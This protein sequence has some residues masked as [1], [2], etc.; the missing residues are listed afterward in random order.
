[1]EGFNKPSPLKMEGNVCENFKI[2]KQEVEI[3]FSATETDLKQN[4]VQIARLLNLMGNEALKVYNVL[5]V[6]KNKDATVTEILTAF[7]V[8]CNPKKN[9]AMEHYKFF[10]YHQQDGEPFMQFYTKLRQLIM[11]CEFGVVEK[12]ILRSQVILGLYNKDVQEKLLRDDPTLEKAVEC[13]ISAEIAEGARKQLETTEINEKPLNVMELRKKKFEWNGKNKNCLND[14]KSTHTATQNL[15]GNPKFKNP[16]YKCNKHHGWGNCPAF[17]KKCE[18]C[19]Q[20]NHFAV[21]CRSKS[22]YNDGN[23][24]VG[25]DSR[26]VHAVYEEETNERQHYDKFEVRPLFSTNII[27]PGYVTKEWVK[28][29]KIQN[30]NI[31]FKLDTGAHTNVIN[32]IVYDSLFPKPKLEQTNIRLEAYGG[33]QIKPVGTC[34]AQCESNSQA[35]WV[36]FIIVQEEQC[37]PILG[38]KACM[39]LG[40]IKR[41]D[42]IDPFYRNRNTFIRAYTDQFSG[43]GCFP[44]KYKILLKPDACPKANPARRVPIILIDRLKNS[45]NQMVSEGIISPVAD[46]EAHEWVSNLVIVEKPD[47]SLRLCLD[48]QHLNKYIIRDHYH[49]PTLEEIKSKLSHKNFYT[50]LDLKNGF[51]HVELDKDSS[52]LC[53]FSS[54]F[55]LY[56][57]KRMP[58]GISS[59]PEVFQKLN[60]KYFGDIEGLIIYFDDFFIFHETREGHDK[61]VA[62][63]MKRAKLYNVKFNHRKVQYCQDEV[64]FLGLIFNK[65]GVS[66]DQTR[67]DSIANLKN[68]NNKKELMQLMGMINYLRDFIPN[69]SELTSPLRGLLKKD[70]EWA[71]YDCHTGALEKIKKLICEAPILANFDPNKET[72]LQCDSSKD[73]L[74]FCLMQEK[75]P[76]SFG[77]RSLTESEQNYAQI[78]KEL[79]AVSYACEKSHLYIYGRNV[80]IYTDHQPLVS[81]MR[82]NF[83]DIKNNRLK[84]IKLKLLTYDLDVQYLPGKYMYI[85]DLLSR[86]FIRKRESDD[87]AMKDVIHSLDS[88]VTFTG[89]NLAECQRETLN[90]NDLK[91]VLKWCKIGW[92]NKLKNGS[93]VSHYFRNRNEIISEEGLLYLNGKL[94]VPKV[95]RK[96]YL[97]IL[98]E[99]HLG[100]VKTKLKARNFIYWPGLTSDIT[101]MISTCEVCLRFSNFNAKNTLIQ[102][103]FPK[104]PFQKIGI[105]IATFANCSYLVIEDYY[106]KWLEVEKLFDKT[107]KSVIDSLMVLFSRFG[108]PES[109][110]SDN[111]PFDSYEYKRF[112]RDWNFKIITS[113]PHFPQSNGMAEKGVGIAKD[114]LRKCL[115]TSSDYQLFLLNYRSSPIA[116][117][118]VSPAQLMFNREIRTK[119]PATLAS[120]QPQ[121]PDISRQLERN[122]INQARY[123][124]RTAKVN[125]ISHEPGEVVM[126]YNVRR[127]IWEKAII[128]QKLEN[129]RS[130]FVKCGSGRIVRRNIRF[131]KKINFKTKFNATS[132]RY[133]DIIINGPENNS[134]PVVIENSQRLITDEVPVPKEMPSD[135]QR[136]HAAPVTSETPVISEKSVLSE[137]ERMS[138]K[139]R[140]IRQPKILD[141]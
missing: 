112:S 96:K 58:F 121:I 141:L 30:N 133:D 80:K 98:H 60:T 105:D 135:V 59:A 36:K 74:G 138:S 100:I 107:S 10:K 63:V 102:R 37:Q 9:L 77:S 126:M 26:Q 43:V 61:I 40:L 116:N 18:A 104:Y 34:R 44:E 15:H 93:E 31:E 82:K 134:I 67:I 140:V 128:I 125:E 78:E 132:H 53:I 14:G 39:D 2:F 89:T 95:L 84:R 50:V 91:Q 86:N 131:L 85:A 35:L 47:S 24:N 87:V 70:N 23:R 73:A 83:S 48:P 57:F 120:F 81:L 22:I 55:G 72:V 28:T 111:M 25:A 68:P 124:N 88:K 139:G 127:K 12:S 4:K 97:K 5:E 19:G 79:L 129:P 52:K 46:N 16:C 136:T 123:Y 33:H 101:N 21:S 49:I 99:T 114:M 130:Y 1:M 54:P 38:L 117:L 76:V 110:Y 113:S 65:N 69:L 62:E 109:V 7:E 94:I 13:C 92:P 20:L 75:K 3:Y 90:D 71:W 8:Y 66:I 103:D 118:G 122:R 106:S 17:N 27:K 29:I 32:S 51:Y 42:Y 56:R 11:S 108:I 119:I 41:I 45:L 137:G 6:S 115:Y 64:K